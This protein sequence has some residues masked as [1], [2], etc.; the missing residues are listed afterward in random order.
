SREKCHPRSWEAG[1]KLPA[2]RTSA[3]DRSAV[4]RSV[5]NSGAVDSVAR[6]VSANE[7][8]TEFV[9]NGRSCRRTK[10]NSHR[11]RRLGIDLADI[12]CLLV[13]RIHLRSHARGL[14]FD[15]VFQA[16]GL[17]ESLYEPKSSANVFSCIA[18]KLLV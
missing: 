17:A 18:Q 13:E 2:I 3:P 4:R 8:L 5:T 6:G 12:L 1:L 16:L 15:D 10:R 11:G 7:R 9:S 14:N